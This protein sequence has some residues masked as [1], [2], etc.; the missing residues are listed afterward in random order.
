MSKES[1]SFELWFFHPLWWSLLELSYIMGLDW[2]DE[3]EEEQ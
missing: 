2:E 3:E 1:M